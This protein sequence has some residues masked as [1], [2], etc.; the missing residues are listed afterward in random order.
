MPS[1]LR[2]KI[3]MLKQHE[4]YSYRIAFYLLENEENAVQAVRQTML[5]LFRRDDLLHLTEPDRKNIVK[6]ATIHHSMLKVNRP[7]PL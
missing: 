3:R 7:T 2:D 1:M 4:A 6:S 5:A